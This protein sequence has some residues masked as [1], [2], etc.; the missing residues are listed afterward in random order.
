MKYQLSG[1]FTSQKDRWK[2]AGLPCHIQDMGDREPDG[3][4][5]VEQNAVDN[6]DVEMGRRLAKVRAALGMTQSDLAAL[7]GGGQSK[8]S[9][10]ENGVTTIPLRVLRALHE[11]RGIDPNFIILGELGRLPYEVAERIAPDVT[12]FTPRPSEARKRG[13]YKARR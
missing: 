6:L 1:Y 13:P 11:Q 5:A 7:V 12:P 3:Q 9:A 10:W 4:N 2:S 8:I